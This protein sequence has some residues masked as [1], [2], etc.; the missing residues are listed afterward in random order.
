M[1]YGRSLMQPIEIDNLIDIIPQNAKLCEIGAW[2]GATASI[3]LEKRPDIWVVSIENMQG[4]VG[5]ANYSAIS[6]KNLLSNLSSHRYRYNAFIGTSVEFTQKI[7][8]RKLFDIVIIDAGHDEANALQDLY[9][10]DILVMHEG[11]IIV[12]DYHSNLPSLAGVKHAVDRFI[13]S[14]KWKIIQNFGLSVLLE[15]KL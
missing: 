10:A 15:K 2:E 1:I 12:H 3:L 6:A 11:K 9:A 13:E 4:G 7:G 8:V 5:N 14:D